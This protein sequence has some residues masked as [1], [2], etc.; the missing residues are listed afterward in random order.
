MFCVM[1]DSAENHFSQTPSNSGQVHAD[2]KE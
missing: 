2:N 1:A